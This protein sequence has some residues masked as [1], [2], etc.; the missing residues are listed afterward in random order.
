MDPGGKYKAVLVGGL[1]TGLGPFV[2]VLNLACCLFPLAG[3]FVAVAIYRNSHPAV[4]PTYNE[5]MVLGALSGLAGAV[6]YAI[7]LIPL[8]L[9]IGGTIADLV[10]RY[11]PNAAEMPPGIPPFVGNLLAN[12]GNLIGLIVAIKV[13]SHLALSLVFGIAGGLIGIAVYGKGR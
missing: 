5:G 13:I 2:P 3:A 12:F 8:A 11:I 10:G 1:I 9:L 7:L 4:T 6:L